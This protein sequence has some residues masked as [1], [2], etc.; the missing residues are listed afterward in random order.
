MNCVMNNAYSILIA[1]RNR[2][3]RD[4]LKREMAAAGYRLQLAKDGREV[5]KW[6][7][8]GESFDLIILDPDLPD[9]GEIMI[10]RTIQDQMP[11]IPIVI[12]TFLSDYTQLPADMRPSALVVKN[13]DSI[14]NLKKVVAQ[15]LET[16]HTKRP[17]EM[18]SRKING[19]ELRNA[20]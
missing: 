9:A 12:H 15:I 18:K 8:S 17:K 5:L 20:S 2:H 11:A 13:G 14:D 19:N 1:D 6:I 3:V 10:L 4:F 7:R 16:S